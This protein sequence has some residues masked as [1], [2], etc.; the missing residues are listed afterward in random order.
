[1]SLLKPISFHAL[2]KEKFSGLPSKNK[3]ADEKNTCSFGASKQTYSLSLQCFNCGKFW[4]SSLNHFANSCHHFDSP[5]GTLKKG[6]LRE[7]DH[8]ITSWMA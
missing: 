1:M 7:A 5:A 6:Y 3:V 2:V 8:Q 4:N